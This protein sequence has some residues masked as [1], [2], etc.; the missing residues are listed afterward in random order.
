MEITI[1]LWGT[2]LNLT[3][4]P[5]QSEDSEGTGAGTADMGTA[6]NYPLGFY[7]ETTPDRYPFTEGD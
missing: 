1:R 7:A 6:P 5:A 2:E 3:I 4:G